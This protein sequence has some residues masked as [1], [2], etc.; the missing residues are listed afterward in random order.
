MITEN[1]KNTYDYIIAGGGMAGLSL[2]FYLSKSTLKNKK[3]LIIDRE[4]K[5]KNDRTWCFW[6]IGDN[7]FEEIIY[8]KWK[9][10]NFKGKNFDK[11]LDIGN[12]NYKMLRGVDF[13]GFVLK[14]IKKNT[15]ISFEFTNILAIKNN[16]KSGIVETE[17]GIFIAKNFVFDSTFRPNFDDPKDH[18]L[19]QH[20][21]GFVIKTPENSFNPEIPV[22][23][24]FQV[25]QKRNDCQFMYVLPIDE[26][27]AMVEFTL[28]SEKLLA[29]KEYDF[30]L[31]KYIKNDLQLVDYQVVEE[32]FGVIPM[33]DFC[34]N[35]FPNPHVLRIGISAG[36]AKPS[37]GYTF[38]RT[39]KNLQILVKDLEKFEDYP[40]Y[41]AFKNQQ[42]ASFFKKRFLFY[43][44]VLLNVLQKKRHSAADVFTQ[45]YQKNPATTIF[46]FLDEETNFWEELKIMNSTPRLKFI[47]AVFDVLWRKFKK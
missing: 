1:P 15:N 45:L 14:E 26:R 43:D 22:M 6:E 35:L 41:S 29:E 9:T 11:N 4:E 47:A 13:Y 24:N 8:R 5:T 16:E 20:F 30:E 33:S 17:K 46:R 34:F 10:V 42:K 18:N 27:T 32:E 2:A 44:S 36:F 31:K 38:A 25:E 19:L 23:M 37:S 7:V 12:Y 39:Q 21:K 28:F 40:T 3:I